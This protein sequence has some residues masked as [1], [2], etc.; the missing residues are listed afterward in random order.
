[1]SVESCEEL[2]KVSA[3]AIVAGQTRHV[4][5]HAGGES[6]SD[7]PGRVPVGDGGGAVWVDE[8]VEPKPM[9][10]NVDGVA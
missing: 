1:M 8:L 7:R 6:R 5:R 10:A 3:A 4:Y 2:R 9:R